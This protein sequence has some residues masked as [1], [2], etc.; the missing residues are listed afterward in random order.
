MVTGRGVRRPPPPPP[1]KYSSWK[2]SMTFG[3][4]Y[5][6][7]I[8]NVKRVVVGYWKGRTPHPNTLAKES[9]LHRLLRCKLYLT[10]P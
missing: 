5:V 9:L 3:E 10:I 8:L 6:P 7:I 4:L 2:H 1:N